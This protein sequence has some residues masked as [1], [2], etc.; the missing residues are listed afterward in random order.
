M[1]FMDLLFCADRSDQASAAGTAF[2]TLLQRRFLPF[3]DT[4]A[5]RVLK[6]ATE[7]FVIVNCGVFTGDRC[8]REDEPGVIADLA[9]YLDRRDLPRPGPEPFLEQ[10]EDLRILPY[11]AIIRRKLPD[12]PINDAIRATSLEA[13]VCDGFIRE[14][15]SN[16]C[17]LELIWSYWHEEGMLV[18]T[19]NA[20]P[21]ASRTSAAPAGP[22]RW[23]TS[24][25]TRCGR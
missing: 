2:T 10:V 22:T 1:R 23:P 14:K 12:V 25:S 21:G 13:D 4:D 18:Q 16:P 5:Y 24:R 19:M 9:G 3:T 17:L 20:I 7:A 8:H 15:L 6:V 11:L